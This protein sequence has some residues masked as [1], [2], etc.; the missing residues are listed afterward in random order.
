MHLRILRDPQF[1]RTSAPSM[2]RSSH[3]VEHQPRLPHSTIARPRGTLRGTP[4]PPRRYTSL[5][6][7]RLRYSAS[8]WPQDWRSR[9]KGT[10]TAGR[11]ADPR[12]TSGSQED[13]YARSAATPPTPRHSR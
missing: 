3:L 7:V 1:P 6:V 13:Q 5:T 2:R 9:W 8:I 11:P 10:Q 4:I 12:K